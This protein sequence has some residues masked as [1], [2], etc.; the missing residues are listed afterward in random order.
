MIRS[1]NPKEESDK[2]EYFV[3]KFYKLVNLPESVR[4][5]SYNLMIMSKERIRSFAEQNDPGYMEYYI[6]EENDG[7]ISAIAM[8]KR[9]MFETMEFFFLVVEPEKRKEGIAQ[10]MTDKM[11]EIAKMEGYSSID[12]NIYADNK[13][14]LRL[15]IK[16]DF[17]PVNIHHHRR[18]DGID[19][20]QLKKYL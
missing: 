3:D 6:D 4:F 10:K 9:E 14:M 5:I 8:L 16:N 13:T 11:I 19:L 20:V 12:A 2:L 15:A 1:F 18:A 17:I 7:S